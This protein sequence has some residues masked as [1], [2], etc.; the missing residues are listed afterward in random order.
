[1]NKVITTVV[2]AVIILGGYFVLNN[3][4][5]P[6]SAT[7][8]PQITDQPTEQPIEQ[9]PTAPAASENENIITYTD[10]GYSP[11]M[12]TIK[13]GETVIFKNQSSKSMWPASAMHPTHRVYSDTSLDDH[14]P[15]TTNSSLDACTGILPGNSWS[16]KF[17]KTGSW[18]FHDH[19][20]P[21]NF[22]KITV[23]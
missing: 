18:G 13:N 12:L 4:Y 11:N 23:E 1:M 8:Q 7:Y 20:N 16:F 5:Q 2:I 9:T 6:T 21:K 22:G 3:S 15:D 17:D 19:L 14:C 10:S